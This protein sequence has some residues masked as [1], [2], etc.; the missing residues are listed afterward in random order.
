[1]DAA[2]VEKTVTL[3]WYWENESTCRW[4]NEH[5]AEWQNAHP[6]RCIGFAAIHP[7]KSPSNVVRQLE[8]AR[9]LGL[10]GVGELHPVLQNFDAR[11]PGWLALAD[12]C[13]T[14]DWPVNMHATEA[15][16]HSHPGNVPTP[17]NDF[18]RMAE[19][20]PKLKL[21]L[22]HWGGGL[23]FYEH[24]PRV[25]KALGNVYYDTAAS[26]LLYRPSVFRSVINIVG[27]E[28]VLF[29]SDYPLRLYPKNQKE[30]DFSSYIE[31]IRQDTGMTDEALEAIFRTN[32][33][34][35]L[36]L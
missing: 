20:H 22:A 32:P 28:K 14:H 29:G 35:L 9:E 27:H 18:I 17:L 26:P 1:M 4:H 31:S 15:A 34:T 13:V 5:I 24:N 19:G 12:W 33:R 8:D 6:D 25:R 2:G 3:G 7:G 16:G 21:I 11:S 36:G 10:R 23:P 30:P